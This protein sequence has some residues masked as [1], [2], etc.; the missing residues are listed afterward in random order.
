LHPQLLGTPVAAMMTRRTRG[1]L[2]KN[3]QNEMTILKDELYNQEVIDMAVRFHSVLNMTANK[4]TT[5][6]IVELVP[7]ITNILN[8]YDE[9]L[10]INEELRSKVT[11][12]SQEIDDLHKYLE[13]EKGKTKFY[14][15]N[16][17]SFEEKTDLEM[18]NLKS[19][20]QSLIKNNNKLIEDLKNKNTVIEVL[21]SDRKQLSDEL[22]GLRLKLPASN[23]PVAENPFCN[24]KSP[25]KRKHAVNTDFVIDTKNRF[26]PL[27]D[28]SSTSPVSSPCKKIQ[29]TAQVHHTVT[30]PLQKNKCQV[31][32][33]LEKPKVNTNTKCRNK[34]ILLS[35]SQ[36]KHMFS[37]LSKLDEDYN[38]FVSAKPGAR[39][40][41]VIDNG[42]QQIKSLT[43][44][45][46]LIILAGTNDIGHHEVGLFSVTQSLKRLLSLDIEATIIINEIPYRYDDPTLNDEIFYINKM[47]YKM[48]HDFKGKTKI[49]IG[50]VNSVL[51][52]NHFTRHG[53]HYNKI[54]KRI[55]AHMFSVFIKRRLQSQETVKQEHE[56]SSV[57]CAPRSNARAAS[58]F[59]IIEPFPAEDVVNV[60]SSGNLQIR[61]QSSSDLR[62]TPKLTVSTP[63]PRPASY[64][65][66][67]VTS[68]ASS[69]KSHGDLSCTS[70]TDNESDATVSSLVDSVSFPP[71]PPAPT[72]TLSPA[73][74]PTL[75]PATTPT[76]PPAPTPTQS[77]AP[78]PTLPPAP[79]P[80]LSPVPTPT[81]SPAQTPTLPPA[82]TPTLPP[83]PTPTMSPAPTPGT[84]NEVSILDAQ[85]NLPLSS[86]RIPLG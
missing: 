45:D 47:V 65:E 37:H 51:M 67:L 26:S 39:L 64:S 6:A 50:S 53:L 34:I 56:L 41:T 29:V 46:F 73:P 11:E 61:R 14:L 22:D 38:L 54:G 32:Q 57:P 44:D 2:L 8:K 82:P 58:E 49:V 23:Q 59:S 18:N 42:I 28:T 16:S 10:K 60:S 55:L 84:S 62:S 66:C 80:T 33:K 86:P 31:K 40:S 15:E 76:L 27:R 19:E 52:R 77:L 7:E 85:K 71:L 17:I 24:P 74:A 20:I 13:N 48:V 25:C 81:L 83:A 75:S 5:D 4:Y 12:L 72:P 68:L 30:P 3:A 21:Q 78:A 69:P 70:S 1:N 43:K 63:L 35:D 9:T 79:T 36:G